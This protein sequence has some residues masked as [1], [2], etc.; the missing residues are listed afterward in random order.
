MLYLSHPHRTGHAPPG[1][2][3]GR[4]PGRQAVLAHGWPMALGEDRARGA[5]PADRRERPAR[6]LAAQHGGEGPPAKKARGLTGGSA[7]QC[8]A[9]DNPGSRGRPMRTGPVTRYHTA[10]NPGDGRHAYH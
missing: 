8:P 10:I 6:F 3:A 2:A 9:P 7:G 5:G 1:P 4:V